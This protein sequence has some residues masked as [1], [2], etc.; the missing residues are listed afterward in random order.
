MK[1]LPYILVEKYTNILPLE[2]A[3]PGNRHCACCIGALSFPIHSMRP[4]VTDARVVCV[5]ICLCVCWSQP[6]AVLKRLNRSRCR[7]ATAWTRVGRDPTNHRVR[8]RSGP[9]P[10]KEELFGG[11]PFHR[12]MH[13]LSS[14]RSIF[15]TSFDRWQKRCGFSLSA[16]QQLQSVNQSCIFRVVQ[17]IKSL[18]DPLEVGNNLPGINDNVRE[19]GLEQKCFQTLTEGRQRRSRDHTVS[20]THLTLPTIYSV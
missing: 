17:V 12:K 7:L 8:L 3:S 13:G 20:Y 16:P 19:R 14:V 11:F 10:K 1:L 4:I 15:S 5:S 2:K 18:Q 9:P 6:W